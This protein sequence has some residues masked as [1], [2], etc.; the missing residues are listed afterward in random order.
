M[1]RFLPIPTETVRAY[2][3]GGGL[4]PMGFCRNGAFRMG[5]GTPV[6]IACG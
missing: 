6:G 4:I 1:L 5:A 2:Q 3:A